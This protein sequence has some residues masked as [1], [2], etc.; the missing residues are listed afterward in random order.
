MTIYNFADIFT[1]FVEAVMLFMFC[2]SFG[3]KREGLPMWLSIVGTVV[4]AALIN[5]SNSVFSYGALNTLCMILSMF[6]VSFI[7]RISIKT[8]VIIAVLNMA[9]VSITEVVI[10][11]FMMLA[12][13]ISAVEAVN[14]PEYRL[15][16]IV[17][18]KSLA[19]LIVNIIRLKHK[20]KKILYAPQYW[21][22]FVTM[23]ITNISVLFLI[24]EFY[25][26]TEVK[27]IQTFSVIGSFMLLVSTFFAL[28]LYEHLAEQ[29]EIIYNQKQYE[30]HLKS[31][32][33]HLD[34]ILIAQNK[35]KKFKHDFLHYIIGI[36]GYIKDKDYAELEKYTNE[37]ESGFVPA[38]NIIETGNSALDAILSAKCDLAESKNIKFDTK[39][40]I[41]EKLPI[42]PIDLCVIF[43]NALD[44]AIEACE[45]TK[46][47]NKE[48]SLS[49][50]CQGQ[51]LFCKIS[52]TANENPTL[53]TEK[54]E[55]SEHGFGLENIKTILASYGTEPTIE[56]SNNQFILKFVIFFEN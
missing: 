7:Y 14:T 5:I 46:E 20:N 34:E 30:Q 50:I 26:Y 19:L 54:A 43:G 3:K 36:K 53:A 21:L 18:S 37:L 47:R 4:L 51:M 49:I 8:R 55:K 16:G 22:F 45:R 39:I 23:L 52:N 17:L 2:G 6:A 35:I 27:A 11:G 25:F 28:Y 31:Q 40:Q 10:M 13:D 38:K 41:P 44:N 48:I 9:L 29:A 56:Y 42:K 33:K 1:G 15:L 32:V 24:F 12:M